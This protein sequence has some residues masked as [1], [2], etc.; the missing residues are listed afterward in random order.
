MSA[1]EEAILLIRSS[2]SGIAH[3]EPFGSFITGT[4]TNS[5]DVDL[6]VIFKE[7]SDWKR[8]EK[9][10]VVLS[11]AKKRMNRIISLLPRSRVSVKLWL[12]HSKTPILKIECYTRSG[13]I[14][15][16]D[17]VL[18]DAHGVL[19]SWVIRDLLL[20][21]PLLSIPL[22]KKVKQ[23]AK[24]RDLIGASF[25]NLSSYAFTLCVIR[26]LQEEGRL[27]FIQFNQQSEPVFDPKDILKIVAS[28]T[29]VWALS[30]PS[31]CTKFRS[32]EECFEDFIK[33]FKNDMDED[34]QTVWDVANPD[35]DRRVCSSCLKNAY[36]LIIDPIS[37]KNIAT[38]LTKTRY[39]ALFQSLYL[40]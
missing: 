36:L 5:D 34:M 35:T 29:K 28:H 11:V 21:S 24:E 18:H 13:S 17:L 19:M 38:V 22:I 4:D 27:G 33:R 20:Q 40:G 16:M 9:G 15:A 14:V 25:G 32:V 2:L 7:A 37:R 12:P 8:D 10:R 1:K 39:N 3:I 30:E 6:A 26:F 31:T 23:W